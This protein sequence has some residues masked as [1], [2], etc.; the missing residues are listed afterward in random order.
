MRQW[1]RHGIEIRGV[2]PRMRGRWRQRGDN[3]QICCGRGGGRRVSPWQR[4]HRDRGAEGVEEDSR[5]H[6]QASARQRVVPQLRHDGARTQIHSAHA[7]QLRAHRGPLRE[8]RSRSRKALRLACFILD[9][10]MPL[11]Q[12]NRFEKRISSSQPGDSRCDGDVNLVNDLRVQV[13]FDARRLD[14]DDECIAHRAPGF[15]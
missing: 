3:R 8:M 15:S 14:G 11:P 6:P 10:E 2:G 13:G 12:R 5:A 9:S 1:R 7:P 4:R